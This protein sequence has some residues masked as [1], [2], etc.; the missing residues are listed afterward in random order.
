MCLIEILD[1]GTTAYPLNRKST[2]DIG[3]NRYGIARSVSR[4]AGWVA[5]PRLRAR[6]AARDGRLRADATR[7]VILVRFSNLGTG[8]GAHTLDVGGRGDIVWQ[9]QTTGRRDDSA[10]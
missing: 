5:P 6:P 10:D 4:A 2:W 1:L 8:L 3:V 7:A 9:T